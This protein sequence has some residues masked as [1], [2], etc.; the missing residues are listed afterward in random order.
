MA[1]PANHIA[2]QKFF[3]NHDF[4]DLIVTLSP[5]ESVN[6]NRRPEFPMHQIIVCTTSKYFKT[7]CEGGEPNEKGVIKVDFEM[8]LEAFR[9]MAAW[10]YG[11]GEQSY[12]S[13]T[14]LA[15]IQEVLEEL[16]YCDGG[17]YEAEE[18]EELR[19]ALLKHLFQLKLQS[20][21]ATTEI[22]SQ[23]DFD[24]LEH[25][26]RFAGPKHRKLLLGL[27]KDNIPKVTASPEWLS[28]TAMVPGVGLMASFLIGMYQD[29][30]DQALVE[31]QA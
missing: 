27:V 29:R 9:V 24:V 2:Y 4:A 20:V 25:V 15:V 13:Q 26:C 16:A 6:P 19:V 21:R 14:N 22:S 10:A 5:P 8:G 18:M 11:Y 28:K 3:N 7:V 23:A 1:G 12:K 31:R 17:S 30:F